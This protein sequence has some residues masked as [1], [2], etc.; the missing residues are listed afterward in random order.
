MSLL[1]MRRNKLKLFG[2]NL[3]F[4]S[5]THF[6]FARIFLSLSKN[7]RDKEVVNPPH[8]EIYEREE[9]LC[10]GH[11]VNLGVFSLSQ[12]CVPEYLKQ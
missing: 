6:L 11:R 8:E 1:Q 2:R 10:P 12:I 7:K 5:K 9:L 4:S 3:L